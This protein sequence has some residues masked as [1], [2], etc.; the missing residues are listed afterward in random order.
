MLR[1]AT[2]V[3]SVSFVLIVPVFGVSTMS[4]NGAVTD[5]QSFV[6]H[7]GSTLSNTGQETSFHLAHPTSRSGMSIVQILSKVLIS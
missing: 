5:M 3:H 7:L 6:L 1:T 4:T 2:L